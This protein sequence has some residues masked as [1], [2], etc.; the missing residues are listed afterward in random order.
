MRGMMCSEI[1]ECENM[2]EN[3]FVKSSSSDKFQF[4]F[5]TIYIYTYMCVI[6]S[7]DDNNGVIKKII[8]YKH[9]NRKFKIFRKKFIQSS[10]NMQIYILYMYYLINASYLLNNDWTIIHYY[11]Y[12]KSVIRMLLRYIITLSFYS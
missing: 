6:F 9:I 12:I 10:V 7:H 3:D 11:F 8:K 2:R 5:M 1:K 4:H